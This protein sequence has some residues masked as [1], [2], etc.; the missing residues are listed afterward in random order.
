MHLVEDFDSV[1]KEDGVRNPHHGGLEEE[2]KEDA[3]GLGLGNLLFV[4]GYKLLGAHERCVQ[5]LE[6]HVSNT[7][8][9]LDAHERCVEEDSTKINN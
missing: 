1:P 6:Q 2:G 9:T 3:R 8:A 4:E 7:L 5:H